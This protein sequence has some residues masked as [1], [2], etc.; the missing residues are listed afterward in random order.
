MKA[1]A[2][3]WMSLLLVLIAGV[4]LLLNELGSS[5]SY[6]LTDTMEPKEYRFVCL[7]SGENDSSAKDLRRGVEA[8][9]EEY[10]VW[11]TFRTFRLSEMNR[12]IESFEEAIEAHVDGIITNIPSTREIGLLIDRAA[13]EKIPVITIGNDINGSQ[14]KAYIGINYYECG[15]KAARILETYTHGLARTVIVLPPA[16]EN[17]LESRQKVLGYSDYIEQKSGMFFNKVYLDKTYFENAYN[18]Y[19]EAFSSGIGYDSAFCLNETTTMALVQYQKNHEDS[20]LKVV[21]MGDSPE[22]LEALKDGY[23]DATLVEDTTYVGQMAIAY[24]YKYKSGEKIPVKVDSE[25]YVITGENLA[26]YYPER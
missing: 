9:M 20:H 18:A 6:V 4:F 24:L 21:G 11:I 13:G 15:E 19:K 23:L 1:K 16:S 12:H 5:D 17:D 25:I 14:R 26:D 2:V 7:F 3:T 10:D 8:A 22:V